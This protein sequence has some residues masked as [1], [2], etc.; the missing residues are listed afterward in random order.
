MATRDDPIFDAWWLDCPAGSASSEASQPAA[1]VAEQPA[2]RVEDKVAGE[3]G[4][5]LAVQSGE[6]PAI[7]VEES[8]P[9]RWG[10]AG[11]PSRR[12]QPART[13]P[14]VAPQAA[15]PIRESILH[16]VALPRLRSFAQRMDA[17]G[18]ETII[19]A[20]LGE[21]PA[22]LRMRLRPAL[23]PFDVP[24]GAGAVLEFVLDSEPSDSATARVWLDALDTAPTE[25]L[26]PPGGDVTA[27]W[28]DH[29]VL[30]FVRR[31]LGSR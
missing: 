30:D 31:A 8:R 10:P 18:H 28:V 20:R 14:A 22:C 24:V 26:R 3:V 17:A 15:T 4:E 1:N 19:D 7:D 21:R 29:V 23:G 6:R 2:V 27:A 25:S 5:P 13:A 9:F 12:P 11:F 16:E